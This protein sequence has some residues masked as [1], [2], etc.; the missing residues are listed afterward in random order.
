[1]EEDLSKNIQVPR[2]FN[3]IP[4]RKK[5]IYI[6]KVEG[7]S[8]IFNNCWVYADRGLL[9]IHRDDETIAIFKEWSS[10]MKQEEHVLAKNN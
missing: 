10:C 3:E 7:D 4:E 9:T 6:V 8:H 1:M 2:E 5:F